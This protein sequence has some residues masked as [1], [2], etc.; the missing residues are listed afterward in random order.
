MIL[1]FIALLLIGLILYGWQQNKNVE[2][3][4]DLG[5]IYAQIPPG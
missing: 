4:I 2:K 1:M 5:K 3:G